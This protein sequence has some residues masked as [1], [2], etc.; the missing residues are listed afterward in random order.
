MT[1][2]AASPEDS[3]QWVYVTQSLDLAWVYAWHA[4]GRGKPKVLVVEPHGTV[5][6]DPEHSAAMDAWRCEWARVSG[7][8]TEPT[9][10][11]E[12]ARSGWVLS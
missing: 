3:D 7:V 9:M 1:S 11:E 6:P 4:P 2:G 10:T 8:L 5:E 12:E